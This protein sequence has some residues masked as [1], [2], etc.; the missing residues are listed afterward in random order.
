MSANIEKDE[1]ILYADAAHVE[2]LSNGSNVLSKDYGTYIHDAQT[3]VTGQKEST[4]KA[5]LKQYR[6]GVMFSIIFSS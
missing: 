3:A 1:K 2:N 6:Y 5:A 4:I